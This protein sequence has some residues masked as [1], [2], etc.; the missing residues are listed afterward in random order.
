MFWL[1]DIYIFHPS[2][3]PLNLVNYDLERLLIS[4]GE[5]KNNIVW[6]CQSGYRA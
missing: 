3:S 1:F 2:F 5:F 4:F 6:A